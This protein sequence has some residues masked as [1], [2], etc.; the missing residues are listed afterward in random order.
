[1]E[2]IFFSTIGQDSHRISETKQKELIL[3]GIKFDDDFNLEANS[4]G[5]VVLHA[6]TN[7]VSGGTG[8]NVLGRMADRMCKN[9]ITDS[10]EYLKEALSFMDENQSIVYLS[11]SIEAARPK[12]ANKIQDM[13]HSIASLLGLHPRQVTITAT[14]GEGLTECGKGNGIFV[15]ALMSFCLK[16]N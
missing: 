13:R 3:G 4:D 11:I 16:K 6:I 14:T 2:N 15:T 5:D 9:G 10:K 12:F 8:V 7:A 1:M